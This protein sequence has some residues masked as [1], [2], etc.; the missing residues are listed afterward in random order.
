MNKY[1]Y[2]GDVEVHLPKFGI[3]AKKGDIVESEQPIDNPD[4]E[5]VFKSETK[6]VA[7]VKAAEDK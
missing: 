7:E 5:Q 4:F 1:K 6:R 2:V 3:T